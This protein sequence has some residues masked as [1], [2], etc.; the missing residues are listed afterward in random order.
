MCRT[1]KIICTPKSTLSNLTLNSSPS[2]TNHTRQTLR[3][4]RDK[5]D[6]DAHAIP[7]A[8]VSVGFE[9]EETEEAPAASLVSLDTVGGMRIGG[10]PAFMPPEQFQVLTNGVPSVCFVAD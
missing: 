9:A 6:A 1:S 10:T 4:T 2:N 7:D 5:R 8:G 3:A